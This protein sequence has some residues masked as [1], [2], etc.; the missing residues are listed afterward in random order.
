M[1]VTR[2][3]RGNMPAENVVDRLLDRLTN[4]VPARHFQSADDAHQREVR[5]QGEAGAI[6]FT[7]QRFDL[8]RIAPDEA[9]RKQVLD[10][11]ADDLR[12]EGGG[13]HFADPLD[14]AGGLQFEE[15]EIA[16]AETRRRVAHDE[17]FDTVEF[18]TFPSYE[19]S[20]QN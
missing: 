9:S 6:T 4:D 18:H 10:H 7:P 19:S 13:I 2:R 20:F 11:L 16:A 8:K 15:H 1:G 17:Y 3:A 14:T 12:T 5:A